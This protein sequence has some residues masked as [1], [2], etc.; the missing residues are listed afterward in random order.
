MATVLCM[1]NLKAQDNT[2]S[3]RAFTWI[4][5]SGVYDGLC[6]GTPSG[7]ALDWKAGA[8]WTSGDL[9]DAGVVASDRITKVRFAV[10]YISYITSCTIEI[11]QGGSWPSS[12][13]TLLRQQN[14]PVSSLIQGGIT[15]VILNNPVVINTIQELWVVYRIVTTAGYPFGIDGN[16]TVN[17]KGNIV[18]ANTSW[19]TLS[20]MGIEGNFILEFYTKTTSPTITT[21]TLPNG[22]I[23][24]AYSQTLTATGS[25]PITWSIESGNL[26]DGL[27]L[28]GNGMISGTPTTEGT[29]NFTVKATNSAGNDTKALS[30]TSTHTWP[31][32]GMVGAG[33]SGDPWQITTHAHLKALADFVNAGNGGVTNGKYYKLMNNIDLISYSN[34][35]P[36]GHTNNSTLAFRG[37]FD[38][39]NKAVQNL[40]INRPSQNCI[41]LFGYCI[42]ASIKNLGVEDCDITGGNDVGSLV[43]YI[44]SNFTV[45]NCYAT[46]TVSGTENVGGLVGANYSSSTISNCYATGTVNGTENVGGLVGKNLI[47]PLLPTAMLQEQ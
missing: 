43:S 6:V 46:G 9:Y 34:W 45:S 21:S 33:T 20:T 29:S 39:N 27:T 32:T 15:E 2:L 26:P 38:G 44:T 12:Q 3:N 17:Q 37:N 47:V 28:S 10:A 13:G 25:S 23:G 31:P 18:Y 14:V 7:G 4:K 24:I 16:S 8:R 11:Y 35:E 5:W 1:S 42:N 22:N 19:T 40:T 30:I 41:G 36:I